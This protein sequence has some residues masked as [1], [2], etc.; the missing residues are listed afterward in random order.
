MGTSNP[1]GVEPVAAAH[2]VLHTPDETLLR[3]FGLVRAV[4][5]LTYL[6]A[7]AVLAALYGMQVWP[8]AIG[9]PVLIVVYT[10]YFMRSAEYPRLSV[11]AS[12][13][14]DCVVIGGL[15]A[16]LGGTSG[17]ALALYAMVVVSAGILLGPRAARLFTVVTVVLSALQLGF[18]ELGLVPLAL[19]NPALSDR[20]VLLIVAG[21]V[22]VSVGYLSAT[23]ASRLHELITEAE[24]AALVVARRGTR[25]RSLVRAATVDARD[26]LAELDAVADA[27]EDEAATPS[28]GELRRLAGRLRMVTSA[29]DAEVTLLADVGA[30]DEAMSR[31]P[32][33]VALHRAVADCV[34]ALAVRAEAH[35]LDVDVPEQIKVLGEPR[36]VRRIVW[37]L[38]ENAVEHTPA[39]TAVSVHGRIAAQHGALLVV[40]DGPGVPPEKVPGLFD[41]PDDAAAADRVG[42]PVVR[43]L[44]RAIGAELSYEPEP[45]G[46]ARFTVAFRLAPSGAPTA[47]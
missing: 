39:G 28:S 14:A 17:G 31:R 35:V 20:V 22:L 24:S 40:D 4:G 36:A 21:A 8:L 44:A 7:V 12:L 37:N 47:D 15:A 26:H 3:R 41:V 23:Y 34:A 42:L 2:A 11:V 13:L 38:I 1:Q 29:V 32:V 46:G 33:P 30:L 6:V 18:E 27:L 19:W 9:V 45:A 43:E 5:G 10:A 25:R 16:V